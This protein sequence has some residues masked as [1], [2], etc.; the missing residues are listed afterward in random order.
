[1]IELRPHWEGNNKEKV[2]SFCEKEARAIYDIYAHIDYMNM[3]FPDWLEPNKT[4]D[5]EDE[6]AIAHNDEETILSEGSTRNLRSLF[7]KDPI[8]HEQVIDEIKSRDEPTVTDVKKIIKEKQH[9]ARDPVEIPTKI[10][11]DS[12][13]NIYNHIEPETVDL[14]LTDPPYNAEGIPL[15]STLAEKAAHILRS[16]GFLLT[17][18]GQFYLPEIMKRLTEIEGLEYVWTFALLHKTRH[19][20]RARDLSI[21][22]KPIIVLAKPPYDL[23]WMSDIIEGTG[24]EKEGHEWQQSLGESKELIERFTVEGD[25]VVDPFLGSGTSIVA[26]KMLGREYFGM[27]ID[28]L[29][30]QSTARRLQNDKY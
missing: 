3:N 28:P 18:S 7:E 4:T 10:V 12:I 25:L 19:I 26:A 30:I 6:C 5:L 21:M 14:I 13:E 24:R 15:F 16:G 22:W 11:C 17:Y 23:P 9:A 1:M 29:A 20:T 2:T 27:D 8:L